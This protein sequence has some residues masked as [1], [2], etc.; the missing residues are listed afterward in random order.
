MT[1]RYLF[2]G[3]VCLGFKTFTDAYNESGKEETKTKGLKMSV[4]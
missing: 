2:E 4:P 3:S 1:H